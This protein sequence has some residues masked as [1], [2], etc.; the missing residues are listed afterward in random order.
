MDIHLS[1]PSKYTDDEKLSIIESL[2]KILSENDDL[3][4]EI[5]WD[6]PELLLRFFDLDWD[7]QGSLGSCPNISANMEI[8]DLLAKRGNAKELFLKSIELLNELNY[9]ALASDERKD[10]SLVDI[11]FH[12]LI[13]LLSAS[14]KRINTIYPSK[15]LAMALSALLKSFVS[16]VQYTTSVRFILRR[17]YSFIRDYIPPVKPDGYMEQHGLTQE[18]A[19]KLEDDENYLQ[20]TL[21]R[22]FSTNLFGLSFK[23]VSA[24]LSVELFASLKSIHTGKIPQF[25]NKGKEME[26]EDGD[27]V[28][29][30]SAGLFGRVVTLMMSQDF[31]FNEEFER[32]KKES[33]D[34]FAS[35][36]TEKYD[37]DVLQKVLQI[38]LTDKISQL[39]NHENEKIPQNEAGLLA[40]TTAYVKQEGRT[41]PI[42]FKQAIAL[43]LRF[44]SP[45][46]LSE[47]FRNQGLIDVIIFWS[48]IS[49]IKTKISDLKEIP[50]Y[51]LMLFMQILLFH[52]SISSKPDIRFV[53]ITLLTRVLTM[54]QES[55]AYEFII[56]TL[57]TAPFENAKAAMV[58]ILKDLTIRD[59]AVASVNDI[60][61][62]LEAS[63]ISDDNN[64]NNNPQ[65]PPKL[66]TR[67][68][69]ELSQTRIDDLYA[70]VQ[71]CIIDSFDEETGVIVDP[72]TF[73]TL[74]NYINLII[75]NKSKFKKEDVKTI[76]KNC[77]NKVVKYHESRTAN[78]NS[79]IQQGANVEFLTM[80]LASLK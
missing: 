70:L 30:S 31:D 47:S 41:L 49:M 40:A 12:V 28:I 13:E 51:Q 38:A 59:R 15:F 45:G 33:V 27:Y 80:A 55:I 39:Y 4:V 53:I 76:L 1:D 29:A 61:M 75:S 21:L 8:F 6:L 64:N 69:I 22:S 37:D 16:Y 26:A 7:F 57:T 68:Y 24:D 35:I 78:T 34:L 60:T 44:L 56:Q 18:E 46:I 79:D 19:Q 17:L 3:I 11:K 63:S 5:G 65:Q 48:W 62:A 71:Q 25:F 10:E 23:E 52:A 58:L 14:L 54:V 72:E 74:L 43:A 9:P 2:S 50:K 73:K 77:E 42:T 36:E 66:P 32:I 20:R 67:K